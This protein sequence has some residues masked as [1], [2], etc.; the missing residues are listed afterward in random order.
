MRLRDKRIRER[1]E[2]N[3]YVVVK[4]QAI[5]LFLSPDTYEKVCKSMGSLGNKGWEITDETI[6]DVKLV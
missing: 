2:K 4:R 1:I 5:K 3:G 6:F